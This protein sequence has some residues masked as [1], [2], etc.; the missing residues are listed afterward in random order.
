[1]RGAPGAALERAKLLAASGKLARAITELQAEL[2]GWVNVGCV[3]R[4]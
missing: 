2:A 3:L 1:M 4:T